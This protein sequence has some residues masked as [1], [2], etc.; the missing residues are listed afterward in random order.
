M[1]SAPL[2]RLL[3]GALL[4]VTGLIMLP[5]PIPVGLPMTL[6][7]LGLLVAVSPRVRDAL[8]ALRGRLPRLS[9]RL[10][11]IAPHLPG[12]LARLVHATTTRGPKP[13]EVGAVSN[14]GNS[15]HT[16]GH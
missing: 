13:S 14:D 4:L 12:P 5:L 7:G 9:R 6:A 16:E 11:A 2:L 8:A 3:G 10:D 15:E 1:R